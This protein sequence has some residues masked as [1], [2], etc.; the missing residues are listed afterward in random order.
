MRK[1]I[2]NSQTLSVFETT[3]RHAAFFASPQWDSVIE[4]ECTLSQSLTFMTITVI[5]SIISVCASLIQAN[6]H[7]HTFPGNKLPKFGIVQVGLSLS[8]HENIP[9]GII[10]GMALFN[11]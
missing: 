9:I 1:Y 4:R 8:L 11:Y 5:G 10:L 7:L 3:V 2:H 6:Q